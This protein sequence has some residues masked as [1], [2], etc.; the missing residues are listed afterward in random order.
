MC[1]F[2]CLLSVSQFTAFGKHFDLLTKTS[3][4]SSIFPTFTF[5][6]LSVFCVFFFGCA[7]DMPVKISFPCMSRRMNYF[8]H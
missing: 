2:H 8:Y 5:H 1:N 4:F 3:S 7:N 6:F